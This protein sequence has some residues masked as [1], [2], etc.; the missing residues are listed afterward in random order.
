LI[1]VSIEMLVF[2]G[3][4]YSLPASL[5]FALLLVIGAV[6]FDLGRLSARPWKT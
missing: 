3:A 5:L 2:S 4:G 1:K 6:H